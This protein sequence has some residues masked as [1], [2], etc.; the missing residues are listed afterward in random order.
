M[1]EA[2]LNEAKL[3]RGVVKEVEDRQAVNL[4]AVTSL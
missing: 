2:N 3:F 4:L 1:G